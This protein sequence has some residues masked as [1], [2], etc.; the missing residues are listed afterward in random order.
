[1]GD[2]LEVK[3]L[4][5]SDSMLKGQDRRGPPSHLLILPEKHFMMSRKT[6]S[7]SMSLNQNLPWLRLSP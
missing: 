5:E 7:I 1:M 3:R 6:L 2:L 4:V